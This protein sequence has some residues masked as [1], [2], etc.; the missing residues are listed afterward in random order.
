MTVYNREGEI[1]P[2][3]KNQSNPP[4]QWNEPMLGDNGHYYIRDNDE[5]LIAG[6][7]TKADAYRA[8]Q[9]VTGKEAA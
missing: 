2:Q 5:R 6:F 4:E 1:M 8:W 3:T 9:S 7:V